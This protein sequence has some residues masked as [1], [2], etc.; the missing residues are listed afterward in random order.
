[1]NGFFRDTNE[2]RPLYLHT[3]IKRQSTKDRNQPYF[4]GMYKNIL[5]TQ[6]NKI[7]EYFYEM[8]TMYKTKIRSKVATGWGNGNACSVCSIFLDNTEIRSSIAVDKQI[9]PAC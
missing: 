8:I 5:H 2:I 3:H 1:M 6:N 4:A 7:V 9:P